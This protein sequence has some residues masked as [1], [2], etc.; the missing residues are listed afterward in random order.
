[1]A[2]G[3]LVFLSACSR[4]VRPEF[5]AVDE[6]RITDIVEGSFVL[7]GTAVFF[8]PNDFGG[9]LTGSDLEVTVDG[10]DLGRIEHR[11][12]V[13]IE[14]GKQFDLPL[15]VEIPIS[16]FVDEKGGLLGAVLSAFVEKEVPIRFD[17]KVTVDLAGLEVDVPVDYT[18]TIELSTRI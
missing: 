10:F 9:T 5:R 14:A 8:N 12:P 15:L 7:E 16:E 4:P 17:G 6:I 3:F 13:D 11:G 1:M 2:A 18:E